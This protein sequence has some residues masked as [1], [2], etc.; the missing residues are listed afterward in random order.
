MTMKRVTWTD[1][2]GYFRAVLLPQSAPDEYIHLGVP[3]EPPNVD[4]IDWVEIKR[5]LHNALMNEGLL[6][7][8]DVQKGQS[9]I[10][11]ICRRVII[12]RVIELYRKSEDQSND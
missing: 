1:E 11:A 3:S 9:R 7:W 8:N 6:T 2:A 12:K 10:S 5:D 4:L